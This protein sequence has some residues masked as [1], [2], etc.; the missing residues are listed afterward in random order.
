MCFW[1]DYKEPETSLIIYQGSL[2]ELKV[3]E[4]LKER[5][6]YLNKS[7]ILRSSSASSKI[8]KF[9]SLKW[10]TTE[11]FIE[12][13]TTGIKYGFRLRQG[14]VSRYFYTATS[15]QLD[16]WLSHLSKIGIMTDI[17]HEYEFK[18][19]IG[20]GSF[21]HVYLAKDLEDSKN[22][23]IKCIPKILLQSASSLNGLCNEIEIM[24]TLDH[25]GIVKLHKVFEGKNH[26]YLVLDYMEGGSM[27][28]R[29]LKRGPLHEE[30][31]AKF[32]A[33]FLGILDYLKSMNVVHRDIK[34]ENILLESE[35]TDIDFKLA[36][37]GLACFANKELTKKCGSPGYVAPEILRKLP[38]GP[39]VDVFSFGII[40]Y[41]ILSGQAPFGGKTPKETLL[42]NIDCLIQFHD[43]YWR[44]ISKNAIE[45]VLQLT[46]S[47]PSQRPSP[48]E[49]LTHKWLRFNTL[50]SSTISLVS[51]KSREKI[52]FKDFPNIENFRQRRFS[53]V[54]IHSR[55]PGVETHKNHKFP[56]ISPVARTTKINWKLEVS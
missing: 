29:L 35:L 14:I 34:L 40:L 5:Y 6:F 13:S 2:M 4:V 8:T 48:R 38:Y 17:K 9:S 51:S 52:T 44:N 16:L 26:V 53:A 55:E 28:D 3:S 1:E 37:F 23:A 50:K 43:A 54:S 45:M 20:S 18:K 56:D 31:A 30:S 7:S 39:K 36:D 42:K 33:K 24:R 25:P 49:A 27:L 32:T 46:R 41:M 15:D 10:K 22:Y 11:P 21:S 12:E 47:H 19:L